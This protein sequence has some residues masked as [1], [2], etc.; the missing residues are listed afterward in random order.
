MHALWFV[1]APVLFWLSW[2][3]MPGVG[4]T[5]PAQIFE[6]VASNRSSVA[7]SVVLQLLSAVFYVPALL[8]LL[9]DAELGRV[10]TLRW[11]AGLLMLGA[12]GSAADAVLHL[13]AFAMTAPNVERGPMIPVMA[14]M[15]GPGLILLAPLIASFFAGGATLSAALSRVGVVSSWNARLHG[16]ALAFVLSAGALAALHLVPPRA[17]GLGYLGVVSGAQAWAGMSLWKRGATV[18][19][20]SDERVAFG[21]RSPS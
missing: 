10:R 19:G 17:V 14:F 20:R 5:D 15:Q 9:A 3:L 13:L 12:M 16:L 2:L 1:A 21:W 6:L 8:G 7:L 18:N 4:V 11:G